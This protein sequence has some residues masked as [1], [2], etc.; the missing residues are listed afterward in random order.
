MFHNPDSITSNSVLVCDQKYLCCHSTPNIWR[1]KGKGTKDKVKRPE[2]PPA[3]SQ[4]VNHRTCKPLL[5]PPLCDIFLGGPHDITRYLGNWYDNHTIFTIF[6]KRKY[7]QNLCF[8]FLKARSSHSRQFAKN[9][10]DYI[11][12]GNLYFPVSD[13][14]WGVYF[15]F[16]CHF[17][18]KIASPIGTF[19]HR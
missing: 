14:L 5:W 12:L 9:L 6:Y 8:F 3:K 19:I 18:L 17:H 11:F 10:V 13:H 4:R 16:L 1:K 15:D 7:G 2:G